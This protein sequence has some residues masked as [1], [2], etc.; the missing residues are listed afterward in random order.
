MTNEQKQFLINLVNTPAP[1]GHEEPVQK[2][3]R[4]EVSSFC[5]EINKDVHGNL[6][7]VLNP[8]QEKSIM[9]VGHADEIGLIINYINNDGFIYVRPVGGVD[10]NILASHRAKVLTKKGIVPAAISRTSLHL[11]NPTHRDK[12]T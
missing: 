1:S 6:T 11:L 9:I 4:D 5:P 3:W 12:K 8:G 10:A 7:A 2:I